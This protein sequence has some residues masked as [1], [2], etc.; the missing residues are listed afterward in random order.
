[1]YGVK[2]QMLAP[3]MAHDELIGFVSLHYVPSTRVWS[4][5]EIATLRHAAA[6]VSRI[7]A[8]HGWAG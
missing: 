5:G 6:Q 8:E 1:V 4:E 3:L 2:A 7:L